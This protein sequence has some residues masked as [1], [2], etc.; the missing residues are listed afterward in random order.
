VIVGH[1]AGVR[2]LTFSPDGTLLLS[3]SV[4]GTA[5]L[6]EVATGVELRRYNR[7]PFT[8]H[9]VAF[10]PDGRTVLVAATDGLAQRYDVDY[11]ATVRYVCGRLKR[12]FSAEELTQYELGEGGNTCQGG[13]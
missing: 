10:A 9:G 6:W 3:G 12:D 4:D 5:R 2:D 8:V 7:R 11:Q 1:A 13:E